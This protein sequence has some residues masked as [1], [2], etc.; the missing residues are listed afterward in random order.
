MSKH[1]KFEREVKEYMNFK[2]MLINFR[3]KGY[4]GIILLVHVGKEEILKHIQYEVSTTVCIGRIEN[5]RKVP[6]WLPCKN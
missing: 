3:K 5:Q 1:M 6:K 4:S 2:K